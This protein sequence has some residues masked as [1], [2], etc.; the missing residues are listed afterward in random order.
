MR[1]TLEAAA[2][3]FDDHNG[4]K[5]NDG[6]LVERIQRLVAS[7][8]PHHNSETPSN[9]SGN[10]TISELMREMRELMRIRSRRAPSFMTQTLRNLSEI[11]AEPQTV[12]G[13]EETNPSPTTSRDVSRRDVVA[14][15]LVP[16]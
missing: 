7:G 2:T 15:A 3:H 1:R 10:S 6:P 8:L 5:I 13:N 16:R 4:S 12:R 11:P 9:M 14:I